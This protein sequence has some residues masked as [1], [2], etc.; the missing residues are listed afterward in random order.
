MEKTLKIEDCKQNKSESKVVCIY[1]YSNVA[2]GV[3]TNTPILRILYWQVVVCFSFSFCMCN[4]HVCHF[5][6]K[7]N[8]LR[9]YGIV[10]GFIAHIFHLV[11]FISS[12]N[13]PQIIAVR[14]S[15]LGLKQKLFFILSF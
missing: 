6:G 10:C 7:N 12:V 1:H 14:I 15:S 13:A 3:P 8:A 5:K 4:C 11:Y 2:K 9:Q